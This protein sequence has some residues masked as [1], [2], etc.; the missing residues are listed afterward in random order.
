MASPVTADFFENGTNKQFEWVLGKYQETMQAKAEGK[1]GKAEALLK[2][3]LVETERKDRQR[4]SEVA[5]VKQ[6]VSRERAELYDE[7]AR[8][9]AET[10]AEVAALEQKHTAEQVR[11]RARF[12]A[13]RRAMLAG[14][15]ED[16]LAGDRAQA[17]LEEQNSMLRQDISGLERQVRRINSSVQPALD[18]AARKQVE[19]EREAERLLDHG[20]AWATVR[21]ERARAVS[22]EGAYQQACLDIDN[23]NRM[24]CARNSRRAAEHQELLRLR[25]LVKELR[26]KAEEYQVRSVETF[27]RAQPLFEQVAELK[28]MLEQ[29]AQ[30]EHSLICVC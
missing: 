16:R 1:P 6:Q 3:A 9:L 26:R 19:A 29:A 21:E 11:Q 15:R 18:C 4:D 10:A 24:I 14:A 7:R 2:F 30:R 27:H 17:E 23:L 5:Q 8:L 20:R 22:A 13:D 25:A 12:A 28:Q